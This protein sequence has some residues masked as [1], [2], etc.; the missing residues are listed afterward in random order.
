MSLSS[1][2]GSHPPNLLTGGQLVTPLGVRCTVCKVLLPENYKWKNCDPCRAKRTAA[3]NRSKARRAERTADVLQD[4]NHNSLKRKPEQ[5]TSS[6]VKPPGR[7]DLSNI[8]KKPR[9]SNPLPAATPCEM[10]NMDELYSLLTQN[11]KLHLLACHSLVSD[12][13]INN[14]RRAKMVAADIQAA[15][16][17]NLG[18]GRVKRSELDS[19]EECSLIFDPIPSPSRLNG[20]VKIRVEEDTSHALG[21]KG[22]KITVEIR[23]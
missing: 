19:G 2:S 11:R 7:L 3:F 8:T 20:P 22:Q 16:G 15:G 4:S 17:F 13:K 12:Q 10:Q 23:Y 6:S 18:K 21:I 5:S 14:F 9:L 1:S